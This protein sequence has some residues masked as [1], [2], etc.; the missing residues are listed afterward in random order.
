MPYA[1]KAQEAYFN[2]NRAKLEK[3][4]VNVDAW[5]KSSK[6]KNLPA[7]IGKTKGQKAT[8]KLIRGMKGKAR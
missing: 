8:A 6:G 5:N 1:S 2:S 3:Q 7:R 4:G